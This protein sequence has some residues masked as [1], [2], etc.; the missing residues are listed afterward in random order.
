MCSNFKIILFQYWHTIIHTIILGIGISIFHSCSKEIEMEFKNE[1]LQVV[2][3]IY[4]PK[5]AFEFYLSSSASIYNLYDT[6]NNEINLELYKNGILILDTLST[7]LIIKTKIYPHSKAKYKIEISSAV[8][9][10]TL[11]TDSLPQLVSITNLKNVFPAGV[12]EYGDAYGEM[13][14]S[15]NDPPNEKN[16]YELH[17]SQYNSYD[18]NQTDKVL[19]NEG[20]LDYFPTSVYFSDELFDGELYTLKI[21]GING[22]Y[23][24]ATKKYY[25][26]LRSVSKSYYLYRK[27]YTRHAYN[28]QVGGDFFDILYKGEPQNMYTNIENG[29]GIFAGYQE[30]T[31]EIIYLEK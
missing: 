2:N 12:D 21:I 30:S 19:L 29:F 27:Y 26:G 18:Y 11:A 25:V 16:Y 13:Q 1:S 7:S 23:N 24:D 3:C 15:F 10:N 5:K 14:V 17:T 20:D 28:Q 31:R 8:F 6:V 9:P 4:S 22:F